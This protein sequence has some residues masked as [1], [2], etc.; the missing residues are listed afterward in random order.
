M[1]FSLLNLRKKTAAIL[2]GI[3]IAALCLWGL[4]IWQDI[5]LAEMFNILLG[6]LIMLA[7]IMLG[8]LIL[9]ASFKGMMRLLS[10]VTKS[11]IETP[12]D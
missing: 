7:A 1:I 2:A 8:A 11:E 4:S 9:I 12:E 3:T 10:K 6:T 5:S